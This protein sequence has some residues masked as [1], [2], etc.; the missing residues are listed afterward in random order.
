M[1]PGRS[2]FSFG[3]SCDS[4]SSVTPWTPIG[5]IWINSYNGS[6]VNALTWCVYLLSHI[7][8]QVQFMVVDS[9][10]YQYS[11]PSSGDRVTLLRSN[12]VSVWTLSH[13]GGSPQWCGHE[14]FYDRPLN[15]GTT[16]SRKRLVLRPFWLQIRIPR[17]ISSQDIYTICP[18]SQYSKSWVFPKLTW[19]DLWWIPVLA[20]KVSNFSAWLPL[21]P[22]YARN[23]LR[24][25]CFQLRVT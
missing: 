9:L 7:C 22:F 16:G 8:S 20:F 2:N 15:V 10:G 21:H 13:L 4:S 11:S 17:V 25:W 1:A 23:K 24:F 5:C 19:P 14:S 18:I 6:K 12:S 3:L